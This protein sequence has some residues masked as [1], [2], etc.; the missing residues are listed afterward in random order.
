MTQKLLIEQ[1]KGQ[2]P[3]PKALLIVGSIKFYCWCSEGRLGTSK[4]ATEWVCFLFGNFI[5]RLFF[6]FKFVKR[7]SQKK[8][9]CSTGLIFENDPMKTA[10]KFIKTFRVQ[11]Y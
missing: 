1:K 7:P 4:N 3:L 8:L 11:H 2:D 10:P 5:G 6:Y 9:L